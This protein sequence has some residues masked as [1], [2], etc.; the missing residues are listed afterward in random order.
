MQGSAV[1]LTRSFS[2]ADLHR[3]RLRLAEL[4]L[5]AD[6]RSVIEALIQLGNAHVAAHEAA[7]AAG[8][9]VG[10]RSVSSEMSD[11]RDAFNRAFAPGTR[12]NVGNVLAP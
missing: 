7:E 5:S 2:V 6:D 1:D 4:D 12:A 8:L 11:P 3:V 10:S 9:V